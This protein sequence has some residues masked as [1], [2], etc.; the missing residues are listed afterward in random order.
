ME[1]KSV[2]P[3]KGAKTE[4]STGKPKVSFEIKSQGAY[5][6]LFI[7]LALVISAV[8]FLFVVQPLFD[9]VGPGREFDKATAQVNVDSQKKTL[10]DLQKLGAAYDQISE[11]QIDLLSRMMPEDKD[12]PEIISQLEAIARQS[13]VQIVSMNISELKEQETQ[14]ARQRLQSQTSEKKTNTP[15]IQKLNIQLDVA[16][17]N[18]STMKGFIESLQSHVRVMDVQR[19]SYSPENQSQTVSVIAYYQPQ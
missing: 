15:D 11:K 18:Y 2:K 12:I 14:S 5:W 13:G 1:I 19:F 9:K 7:F 3:K 8:A 16:A 17:H 6:G 10:S 4:T